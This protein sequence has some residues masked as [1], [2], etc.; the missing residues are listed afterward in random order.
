MAAPIPFLISSRN[1]Q[2]LG[3]TFLKKGTFKQNAEEIMSQGLFCC[4]S[5]IYI[6]KLMKLANVHKY[7]YKNCFIAPGVTTTEPFTSKL[8]IK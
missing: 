4:C 8:N 1:S 6:K 3:K 5:F 2:V 7:R